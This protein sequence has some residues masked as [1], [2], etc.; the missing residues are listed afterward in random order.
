MIKNK[1]QVS[2]DHK[3]NTAWLITNDA[4]SGSAEV[5]ITNTDTNPADKIGTS[6]II[7]FEAERVAN[8]QVRLRSNTIQWAGEV[9]PYEDFIE[10]KDFCWVVGDIGHITSL[11]ETY[12]SHEVQSRAISDRHK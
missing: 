9:I 11:I 1:Y 12:I 10:I 4:V 5:L 7:G 2:S 6:V 8:N 3:Y